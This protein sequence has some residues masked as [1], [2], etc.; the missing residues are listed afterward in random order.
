[1]P[2]QMSK[3]APWALLPI[4]AGLSGCVLPP[5]VTIASLVANAASYAATGK[6]IS[7]HGIS[8]LAGEDCALWRVA[9]DREICTA[10]SEAVA[11][12]ASPPAQAQ[13]PKSPTVAESG[14][15]AERVD[16]IQKVAVA[17]E[18]VARPGRYWVL[19]SFI[20]RA[21]AQHLVASLGG[22]E[23]EIVTVDLNGE[24]FH[25]VIAGPLGDRDVAALHERTA[26]GAGAQP[27]EI[28]EPGGKPSVAALPARTA[29]TRLS[30]A[31][32]ITATDQ[33]SQVTTVSTGSLAQ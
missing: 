14:I 33:L 2:A 18:L 24:T 21:N 29:T 26:N 31:A 11:S 22:M 30:S 25:R 1:M 13:P 32:K 27:W 15:D 9:A 10:R 17:P 6:S 23:A 5:A 3:I 4:L 7:D 16:S 19:G 28:S 20:N 12:P 8:A